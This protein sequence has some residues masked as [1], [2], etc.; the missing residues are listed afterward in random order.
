MKLILTVTGV[1][2]NGVH[3]LIS[4]DSE[5]FFASGHFGTSGE[6][7][8]FEGI[9]IGDVLELELKTGGTAIESASAPAGEP[10]GEPGVPAP[11]VDGTPPVDPAIGEPSVVDAPTGLLVNEPSS[12]APVILEGGTEDAPVVESPATE[13]QVDPEVTATPEPTPENSSSK[14]KR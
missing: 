11:S 8:S 12:D 13:P 10:V 1:F 7:G 3:G 2:E 6:P 14:K 4:T 9:S 5:G